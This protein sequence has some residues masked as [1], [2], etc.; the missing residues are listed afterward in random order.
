MAR[1]NETYRLELE[2][3]R[4][5]FPNQAIINRTELMEYLGRN[6]TWL[7]NHGFS[8]K[9]FTLVQVAHRLSKM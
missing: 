9:D 4:N 1:E 7:D 6:R 2:Q 8:G 3:L 5:R